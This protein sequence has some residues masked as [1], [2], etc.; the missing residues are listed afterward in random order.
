IYRVSDNLEFSLFNGI[1]Y[2]FPVFHDLIKILIIVS[3]FLSALILSSL[4]SKVHFLQKLPSI[5]VLIT[6]MLIFFILSSF[7]SFLIIQHRSDEENNFHKIGK[8][9]S[10]N[11]VKNSTIW[12]DDRDYIPEWRRDSDRAYVL[13]HVALGIEFWSENRICKYNSSTILSKQVHYFVSL[14]SN[15]SNTILPFN[16]EV[17]FNVTIDQNIL[18]GVR[19]ELVNEESITIFLFS[20]NS[21]NTSH[22][23]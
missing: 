20:Y 7:A 18:E 2:F 16:S 1:L 15:F 5:N 12:M 23:R 17:I 9:L 14:Y 22:F 13:V 4:K 19:S 11:N 8:W 21:Y 10:S 6:F 3:P